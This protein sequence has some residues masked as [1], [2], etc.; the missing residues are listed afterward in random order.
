MVYTK[1][2]G[3]KVDEFMKRFKDYCVVD[4]TD[5]FEGCYTYTEINLGPFAIDFREFVELETGCYITDS[6]WINTGVFTWEKLVEHLN[7]GMKKEEGVLASF[8]AD[9]KETFS[10]PY[11]P[12]KNISI[13]KYYRCAKGAPSQCDQFYSG[14]GIL[15]MSE[16]DCGKYYYWEDYN[17]KNE[18]I[19][20]R[21]EKSWVEGNYQ[22]FDFLDKEDVGGEVNGK[23][24][25][26]LGEITLIG[27]KE[28]N[29]TPI[30][31]DGG[32]S[33]YY[34]I[35]LPQWLMD[36]HSE[37]GFIMLEDLAE[38]MFENDFNFTNVFKAQKRMFELTKGQGKAGND[39]EYDATKC[40]YYTDKQ[41]EVFNRDKK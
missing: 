9:E 1:I 5:V 24:V 28:T 20:F 16:S 38:I 33:D 41:V 15:F 13:E 21:G 19:F 10:A 22:K 36:K 2:N 7:K 8:K 37:N 32:K 39:F 6:D 30:K 34:K 3:A 14:N 27:K 35:E 18:L 4:F 17:S 11:N 25:V 40:K 12:V 26:D 23:K 31:S 29:P